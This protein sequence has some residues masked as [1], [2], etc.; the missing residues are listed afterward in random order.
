MKSEQNPEI[1]LPGCIPLIQMPMTATFIQHYDGITSV[2]F[3]I[4]WAVQ[5]LLIWLFDYIWFLD[6]WRCNSLTE[7]SPVLQSSFRGGSPSDLGSGEKVRRKRKR[8]IFLGRWRERLFRER[9][10]ERQAPAHDT[11][12][13]GSQ[14]ENKLIW[15]LN[16]RPTTPPLPMTHVLS[17]SLCRCKF[18]CLKTMVCELV[19][20]CIFSFGKIMCLSVLA[21]VSISVFGFV[22]ILSSV[23]VS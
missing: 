15:I 22:T 7:S 16:L 18:L 11:S 23:F 4:P 14:S 17:L 13:E 12:G 9:W 2:V 19:F 21:Y 5:I 1:I 20:L 8:K 10:W 6:E 3:K